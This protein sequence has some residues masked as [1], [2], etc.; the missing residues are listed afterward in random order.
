L[1]T[2]LN[3]PR[4][5][6]TQKTRIFRLAYKGYDLDRPDVWGIPYI[7]EIEEINFQSYYTGE[8]TVVRTFEFKTEE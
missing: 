2:S 5:Q 6:P 7:Y 4:R 8:E 3:N 1:V